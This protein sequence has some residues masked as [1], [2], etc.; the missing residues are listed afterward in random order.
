V[1]RTGPTVFHSAWSRRISAAALSHSLEPASSSARAQSDSFFA[2][3]ADQVSLRCARSA[4]RRVK[5]VSHASRNRFHDRPRVL[6]RHRTDRL[7]FG[8]EFLQLF[9]GL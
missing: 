8:L 2:W 6:P 1:R 5:K 9:R 3:F 4:F 7:P